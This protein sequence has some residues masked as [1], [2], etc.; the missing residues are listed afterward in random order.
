[1][2]SI[3][4]AR[5]LLSEGSQDVFICFWHALNA[6]WMSQLSVAVCFHNW[7][8]VYSVQSNCFLMLCRSNLWPFH[9]CFGSLMISSSSLLSLSFL[10]FLFFIFLHQRRLPD[11]ECAKEYKVQKIR[12]Q[13]APADGLSQ[14]LPATWRDIRQ[15]GLLKTSEHTVYTVGF[16]RFKRNLGFKI[17]LEI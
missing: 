16:K 6:A 15:G 8:V 5:V 13:H 9:C 17:N 2:E 10:S 1:M 7:S 12:F 3:L 4:A 14:I 11:W